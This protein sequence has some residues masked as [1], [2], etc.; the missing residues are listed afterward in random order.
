MSSLGDGKDSEE[1]ALIESF[2]VL[3]QS[4]EYSEFELNLSWWN[5]LHP[6]RLMQTY[7]IPEEQHEACGGDRGTHSSTLI[8]SRTSHS[9]SD[10]VWVFWDKKWF[11]WK[12]AAIRLRIM[13]NL[14]TPISQRLDTRLMDIDRQNPAYT[15]LPE[16]PD[17]TDPAPENAVSPVSEPQPPKPLDPLS[18]TNSPPKERAYFSD[19]YDIAEDNETKRTKKVYRQWERSYDTCAFNLTSDELKSLKLKEGLNEATFTVTTKYQGTVCCE[20]LIYLWKSTDKVVISDI[21][22]TI[23]RSDILGHLMP[24]VGLEW[25]QTGVTKLYKEIAHNGF[26]I[27]YVSARAIGQANA[28]RSLLEELVQDK[29]SLPPGPIILSP[30][31]VFKTLDM[32]MI[33]KRPQVLK[34]K[35]LKRIQR[36][37]QRD[38][39]KTNPFIAGFGNRVSDEDTYRAVGIPNT[40]IFIVNPRGELTTPSG[41]Q[42]KLGYKELQELV[43]TVF[44]PSLGRME[45]SDTY[46]DFTYWRPVQTENSEVESQIQASPSPTSSKSGYFF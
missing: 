41:V 21:D 33:K 25:V 45:Y 43:E 34:I 5:Q 30:N 15:L 31:S 26:H 8:D 13:R 23:T 20:C 9:P 29:E 39:P 16:S 24:L 2:P 44:P 28:T 46:S 7:R 37:F 40:H 32:E 38:D 11:S 10:R 19:G 3:F 36:L 27:M 42:L 12:T 17:L 22:G 1:A 4:L 35:N 6:L 18:P 14:N